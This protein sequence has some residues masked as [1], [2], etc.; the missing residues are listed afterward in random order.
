MDKPR[1]H[2]ALSCTY[3]KYQCHIMCPTI[4][5][6]WTCSRQVWV[7]YDTV[8]SEMG[9]LGEKSNLIALQIY[10]I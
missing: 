3:I 4:G 2:S 10:R 5:P 9:W 1:D 8:V 6:L 7:G